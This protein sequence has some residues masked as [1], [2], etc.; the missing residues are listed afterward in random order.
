MSA[1]FGRERELSTLRRSLERMFQGEGSLVIVSGEAGIGKT[2]LVNEVTGFAKEQG[3]LVLT[4]AAYDLSATPPYGPWLELF[5]RY[6]SFGDLPEIPNVLRPGTGIGD[7]SSQSAL[8]D[9][10]LDFVLSV[11]EV[12]P[13]VLTLEDLHWSDQASLDGLRHITRQIGERRVLIIATYRDDEI[14]RQHPLFQLLPS[15]VRESRTERIEVRPL[16]VEAI[17]QLVENQFDLAPGD[18]SALI[19]YLINW[20][21]GNPLFA[22]ELLRTLEREGRVWQVSSGWQ[23]DDLSG[24]PVPSLIRQLIE[25]RVDSLGDQSRSAIRAAAV[26]GQK[27]PLS[28]W[29]LLTEPAS[30]DAAIQEAMNAGLVREAGEV[31]GIAF[32]HALIREAVYAG[33]SL[34]ERRALH[35][36]LAELF[37]SQPRLDLESISYH[38]K[39]AGD[40]RAAEWLIRAGEQAERTFAWHEAFD[41]YNEALDV[42]YE[43]PAS[44][45]TIAG[46][47]LKTARLLRFLDP[48]RARDYLNTAKRL[49]LDCGERAIAAAAQ[50]N[51]GTN[52]F[53]LGDFRRGLQ[54]MTEAVEVLSSDPEEAARTTRWTQ[55]S[56]AVKADPIQAWLGALTMNLSTAGRFHEAL[57]MGQRSLRVRLEELHKPEIVAELSD[58]THSA[59]DAFEGLGVAMAALGK[60]DESRI[61]FDLSQ[62]IH[63]KL[64]YGPSRVI[65]S[66][67]DLITNH[68]PYRADHLRERA[69]LTQ[70]IEDHLQVSVEMVGNQNSMWGYEHYLV[71]SGRWDELRDLIT[72]GLTPTLVEYRFT[73]KTARAR[74]HWY[75]GNHEQAWKLLNEILRSGPMSDP[76]ENVFIIP[77]EPHRIAAG[78]ALDAG[79]GDLARKWMIAHDAWLDWSDAVL[80][81]ADGQLLW[82]RHALASGDLKGAREKA[83]EALQMARE[84]RQPLAL[85]TIHRFL[86]QLEMAGGNLDNAQTHLTVS[87]DLA[88]AC[89]VPFELASSLVALAELDITRDEQPS[90]RKRLSSARE[91]AEKLRARPMLDRIEKLFDVRK[92]RNNDPQFGL[93]ARET[94]VL[95]LLTLGKTDRE[96]AEDL[97]ISRH[98]VMR[99]V[100]NILRKLDVTS[101]TAA[102]A[103]AVR[104]G[105]VQAEAELPTVVNDDVPVARS[106]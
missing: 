99:H 78:L 54:E 95:H 73:S 50:F 81:R 62:E 88:E 71:Y 26:I 72:S 79:A 55:T 36:K 93:S 83:C 12:H 43:I 19:R 37:M 40:E 66:S 69:H 45:P 68:F 94:E 57:D 41:R 64:N 16:G 90:A 105:I 11:S 44:E 51:I 32:R 39:R 77:A 52:L 31:T 9:V 59:L 25:R 35:R 82:A 3:A 29:E 46:L 18:R 89:A 13:V 38:L 92:Q 100:S 42:L 98:T 5:E 63:R 84:P 14:T 8:F 6:R 4:G 17:T 91:I 27:V 70:I 97:F 53:N 61:A 86:G 67:L 21:E 104:T 28:I 20:S 85:I 1:F 24:A 49:A 2:S 47:M 106:Q 34:H 65:V 33:I 75:E 22:E 15:L 87:R 23:L 10:A 7:L 56:L 60:P 74:M 103:L 80:G 96:I 101:R 76:Q 58:Q 102:S 48:K 30:L